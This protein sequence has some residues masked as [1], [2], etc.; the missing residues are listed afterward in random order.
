MMETTVK[1]LQVPK[2]DGQRKNFQTWLLRFNAFTTLCKFN[3]ALTLNPNM[4]MIEMVTVDE[5][6][7]GGKKTVSALRANELAMANLTMLC[8]TH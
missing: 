1:S 2:F 8:Q 7:E 3:K 4:P 6:T 5:T